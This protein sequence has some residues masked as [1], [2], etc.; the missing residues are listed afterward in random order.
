MNAVRPRIGI[1]STVVMHF[2]LELEDGTVVESTFGDEPHQMQMGDGTLVKGLEL[3][4]YGLRPGDRERL[5]VEPRFAYGAWDPAYL[6]T[7]PRATFSSELVLEPGTVI[8][9]EGPEGEEIPGT[10]V[11]VMD[12]EVRVDFNHPLA[13]RDIVFEVEVVEVD[14]STCPPGLG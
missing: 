7:L 14:N 2:S 9:F 3:A 10:I 4:L 5:H 13:G 11:Q 1:R 12:E 8:A 6:Q